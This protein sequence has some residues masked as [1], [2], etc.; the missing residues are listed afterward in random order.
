MAK[1]PKTN[2]SHKKPRKLE[3]LS[4]LLDQARSVG[5]ELE[6]AGYD[7]FN[8][9]VPPPFVP[10]FATAVQEFSVPP[11]RV[12]LTDYQKF[13]LRELANERAMRR[14]E[15]IKIYEPLPPQLALHQS[16]ALEKLAIGANRGTKTTACAMELAYAVTGTHPW[17]SGVEGGYPIRNGH[18]AIIGYD[19]G[20]LGATIFKKLF[21]S[22]PGSIKIIRDLHTGMW[23][24]YR[25]WTP[26]DQARKR[27]W[28]YAP[29]LIPKRLIKGKIS[30]RKMGLAIPEKVTLTTGWELN[31]YSS[32]AKPV[33]GVP[34]HLAWF[35]EEIKRQN[36]SWYH[37]IVMRMLDY[38]GR[39]L[40][41]ATPHI[42][43]DDLIEL[44]DRAENCKGQANPPVEEF[45]FSLVDNPHI[46]DA[47]KKAAFEKL[48]GNPDELRVRF[49]G[50]YARLGTIVYPEF[51][52][53]VHNLPQSILAGENRSPPLDW[54]RYIA[55]D[56]GRQVCAALFCA[57]PP[58]DFL[59]KH[60]LKKFV[61]LYDEMYIRQCDAE[62]FG[63]VMEYKTRGQDFE[64][65]LIDMHGGRVHDAGSG[66]ELQQ[67]YSRMLRQND[68]WNR[69]RRRSFVTAES[70]R[71][72]GI[73]SFREWLLLGK[74]DTPYVYLTLE[75]MP[76][77]V[78]EF[79]HWSYKKVE[80][81]DQHKPEERNRHL[82]DCGRYL[83]MYSPMYRMPSAASKPRT[84]IQAY[85]EEK[86]ARAKQQGQSEGITFG[87][88]THSQSRYSFN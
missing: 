80:G 23:R 16:F 87:P 86:Q 70:D 18:A 32:K 25:P 79:T 11:E 72:Q 59:A 7:K 68:V 27:D 14:C 66:L 50:E 41:S 48:E 62:K 74:Q 36:P 63:T 46:S 61:L 4:E 85:L 38:G 15:T 45:F 20:H 8:P 21:L 34:F 49:Y 75:N 81:R 60:K 35:D 58:P 54:A 31:F 29:P 5:E 19:E 3:T 10:S 30:W 9:P 37:E 67:Q 55:L 22:G 65:I 33:Q 40:W 1:T 73:E 2:G 83:A 71:E 84:A 52:K 43:S 82:M 42:G 69:F 76:R 56:P 28:R 39:S 78:H 26:E 57:V 51:S 24:S 88:Q 13:R 77:S 53:K 44:H 47:S 17:L 6:K 12:E 64:L